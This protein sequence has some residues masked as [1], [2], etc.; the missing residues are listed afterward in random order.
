MRLKT[1]GWRWTL[2]HESLP[3]AWGLT[4]LGVGCFRS[5]NYPITFEK[6]ALILTWFAA[7]SLL[8]LFNQSRHGRVFFLQSDSK[9]PSSLY[10]SIIT[11]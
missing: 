2:T 8:D 10:Y 4:T 11:P 7:L 5:K 1:C 6:L 3:T 9:T